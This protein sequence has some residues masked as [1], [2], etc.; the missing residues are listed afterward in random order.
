MAVEEI[1]VVPVVE[2]RKQK[3]PHPRSTQDGINATTSF[4]SCM[5]RGVATFLLLMLVPAHHQAHHCPITLHRSR[6][7]LWHRIDKAHP[8]RHRFSH[9]LLFSPRTPTTKL[10]VPRH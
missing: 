8:K 2:G 7:G 4:P 1:R 3:L 5:I 10:V 6:V 9:L